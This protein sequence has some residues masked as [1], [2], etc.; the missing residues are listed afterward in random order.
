MIGAAT[1]IVLYGGTAFLLGRGL[2]SDGW[3]TVTPD[4]L[5]AAVLAGEVL[6]VDIRQPDEWR[7]SGVAI[8][9]VA[10]DMRRPDF[11]QALSEA[12]GGSERPVALICARGVRSR[13][14]AQALEEAG[15]GPVI[16]VPEG[17]LGSTAGP[18]W[19]KMGLPVAPWNG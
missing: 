18:G 14:V 7:K 8:G 15:I 1:A 6:L 11:V 9:A 10:I 19:I 13:R 17:M 4:E 3:G 5:F 2:P 16:D 12:R